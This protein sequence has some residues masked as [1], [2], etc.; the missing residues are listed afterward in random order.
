MTMAALL[1]L[2]YVL[3]RLFDLQVDRDPDLA[4]N[5]CQPEPCS[6][7][8]CDFGKGDPEDFAIEGDPKLWCSWYARM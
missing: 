1:N 2:K 6:S 8:N 7:W 5:R 4:R 3:N